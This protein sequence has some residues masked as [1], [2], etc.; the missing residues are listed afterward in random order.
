MTIMDERFKT[1][2]V[3]IDLTTWA[4][5]PVYELFNS[6]EEP[7]HG[8]CL[9]VDC[10]EAFRFAK[11][12]RISV[13]LTL[14][15]RS[16]MAA[17]QVE[18]LMTRIVDGEVWRYLTIHGGSAIGRPNGTIGFGHYLYQPEL[19]AFVRDASRELERVKSTTDLDRYP[20][21]NL[22]RFSVLPWFDFTSISHARSFATQDSAPK[23]TFGKITEAHGRSTMP[24]SIHVHHA[25]ADGLHVAQFVEHFER[26]L[27]SP[28][29]L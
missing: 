11:D 12:A 4:R 1:E 25:L 2:A 22:I 26:Y 27:A 13:F 8:V 15:H 6:F 18:N 14:L 24:V 9:R 3:P 5:R 7:F 19:L 10:T 17:H 16:L 29:L 21:Q 20:G 28:E 23:I